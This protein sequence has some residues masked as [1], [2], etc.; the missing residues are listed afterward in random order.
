MKRLQKGI[1]SLFEGRTGNVRPGSNIT[2]DAEKIDG[3]EAFRR[4]Y[5]PMQPDESDAAP[6]SDR[7]Q[8]NAYSAACR[9]EQAVADEL[10][11]AGR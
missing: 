2:P 1:R 4:L 3:L 5:A 6:L 8:A 7:K 11:R 9:L 10:R